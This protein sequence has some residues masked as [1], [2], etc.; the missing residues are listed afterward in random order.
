MKYT[1][2]V[3][4][5]KKN[6]SGK[7]LEKMLSMFYSDHTYSEMLDSIKEES[8]VKVSELT[9]WQGYKINK[10]RMNAIYSAFPITHNATKDTMK[11]LTNSKYRK[12]FIIAVLSTDAIIDTMLEEK[13]A[14]KK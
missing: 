6:V 13:T 1:V 8:E 9:L 7:K 2:D 10:R 4:L 11:Y 5:D 3:K 14:K 12:M